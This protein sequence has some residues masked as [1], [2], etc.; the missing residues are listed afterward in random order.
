M[1]AFSSLATLAFAA[2][3][4]AAP[5]PVDDAPDFILG[6]NKLDRRQDYTQN[7]KTGGN[8]NFNPTNNGYS[9]QFSGA[10]DFVVGKG[11]SRGSSTR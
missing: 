5:T 1:V 9:V 11:W 4:F 10:Q 7:Y 6:G 2:F 3:A 8:V